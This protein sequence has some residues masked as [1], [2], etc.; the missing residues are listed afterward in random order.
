VADGRGSSVRNTPVMICCWSF[1]RIYNQII[2][3][4]VE[5]LVDLDWIFKS[6]FR[7]TRTFT[8][9]YTIP[10]WDGPV[11]TNWGRM[12]RCSWDTCWR[13]KPYK[14]KTLT[15]LAALGHEIARESPRKQ[16]SRMKPPQ[17]ET[18]R[19][20][21]LKPF[22]AFGPQIISCPFRLD[23]CLQQAAGLHAFPRAGTSCGMWIH[24]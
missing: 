19:R 21:Q 5:T 3:E 8:P 12:F 10:L 18:S 20:R 4:D 24:M 1:S 22:I 13:L 16:R 17:S 11:A 15:C 9:K 6:A 7:R 14:K 23:Y 2:N